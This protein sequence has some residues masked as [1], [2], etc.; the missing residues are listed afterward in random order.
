MLAGK[1]EAD[2]AESIVPLGNLAFMRPDYLA[3]SA[4]T[5]H[6]PF[7]FWLVE[8]LRPR[9]F[10]ELGSHW[11]VSYFAFCQA[12]DR[13]ALGAK[14]FAVDTWKGDA[15]AGEY[16]PEVFDAV[17]DYNAK[18]FKSFS[19]LL[20]QTFDE[21]SAQFA[22]GSIDL[23]HIDGFH[24]YEAV[25]HDFDTWLPKLSERGVMVFHDTNV[26][27]RGF[28]V[29]QLLDELRED[30]P[31]F[32]FDHGYGL[33]VVGVG[34]KQAVQLQHL[35]AAQNDDRRRN[36]LH[37]LF[38][39]LG[40][41]A[42]D[43]GKC[44]DLERKLARTRSQQAVAAHQT[45]EGSAASK[46]EW[47][48]LREEL[49]SAVA[50]GSAVA[51]EAENLKKQVGAS[52][53]ELARLRED[54]ATAVTRGSAAEKVAGDLKEQVAA[55]TKELD[56]IRSEKAALGESFRARERATQHAQEAEI[57][58]LTNALQ[59]AVTAHAEELQKL[60]EEHATALSDMKNKGTVARV[61]VESERELA[62]ASVKERFEEIVTLTRL[63][64]EAEAASSDAR[65]ACQL[66]S[67][68]MSHVGA[69]G[70][71][72][73]G[74]AI[75]HALKLPRY[76]DYVP[77]EWRLMRKVSLLK[78]T[79]LLDPEW[80]AGRYE[81]VAAAGDAPWRHYV[82]YGAAEGREPNDILARAR[83]EI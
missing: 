72:E 34:A 80:Y 58:H 38:S 45:E 33:G 56:R 23:V 3:P 46:A 7:A 75:E 40:R 9:Q 17:R 39:T 68:T 49:T 1:I 25:R 10:V 73:V 12:L 76:W 16:G 5:E 77:A 41:G 79:G 78:E 15:H 26:R 32:E 64:R 69:T 28:G 43:L 51:K 18:H 60:R 61:E 13:L 74:R 6:V 24:T 22:D 65:Q 66:Q 50:G 35:Y 81:D 70:S 21:A 8:A 20:K 48:R 31:T 27:E 30:Y 2:E 37:E 11:G 57:S 55:S 19:C 63:L 4:W 82:E 54:L 42:L 47:D 59:Q 62:K 14:A 44:Q 53:A 71:K 83:K 67:E 29:F 36:E 52:K